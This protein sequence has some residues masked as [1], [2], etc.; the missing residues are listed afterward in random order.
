M[1]I[2]NSKAIYR[3]TP[4]SLRDVDRLVPARVSPVSLAPTPPSPDNRL[5]PHDFI[6]TFKRWVN[7]KTRIYTTPI[8]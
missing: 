7:E 8:N 5:H 6:P 2:T 4:P 3:L 1:Y